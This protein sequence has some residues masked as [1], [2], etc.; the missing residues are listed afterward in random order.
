M[1]EVLDLARVAKGK[2]SPNPMVGAIIVKG[3]KIIAK[4]YHKRCGEDHAELVCIKKGA[5]RLKGASLYVNL[6]PCYHYGKTSP[7]VDE[8]IK[9]GI[10]KVIIGIKDSNPLT[11]GRSIVKLKKNGIKVKVGV[12]KKE[13]ERLN[14]EFIKYIKHKTPFIVSKTAQTIDGKIATS[15]GSSK[16]ITSNI[17]RRYAKK[18]RDEFDAILVGINTVLKDDP[19]LNGF[20]KR[21]LKKII[22]DTT[23]KIS[24]KS[25]I[26]KKGK[27][28]NCFV[29]TTKK[30][31]K[32]KIKTLE[33]KG[34][35]VIICPLKEGK[36][37]LKWLL[38]RLAK[39]EVISILLEG[40]SKV[41]GNALKTNWLIKCIFILLLKL[42][43]IKKH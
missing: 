43:G 8:I 34:I 9:S 25:K 13:C 33:N 11:K 32:N 3:N 20:K 15:T 12:L 41:V 40:G 22:L 18:K 6:E 37:D 36:I 23:L 5:G 10:K 17:T 16:W 4:G 39:L 2:T 21:N 24:L 28:N 27:L 7:C 29:A 1:K 19:G 26:F 31:S 35:N 38:K 14:E 30:A 42:L